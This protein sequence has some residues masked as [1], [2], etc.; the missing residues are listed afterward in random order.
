MNAALILKYPNILFLCVHMFVFAARSKIYFEEEEG[1]EF[2]ET[3]TYAKALEIL[4]SENIVILSG[5]PGEGK[6]TMA[7]HLLTRFRTDRCINLSEPKDWKHIDF[8]LNLI[9][10]ILIDDIFGS[11]VL[12]E[13]LVKN[14]ERKLKDMS[15]IIK[16]KYI[17]VIITSRHYILEE[18]KQ[19]FRSLPLFK[20]KNI[21]LL[22]SKDLTHKEKL[23]IL[24]A[25]LKAEKRPVEH[26]DMTKCVMKHASVPENLL[27]TNEF[28]FG[29]P[30]SVNLFAR[31]D[32][33][34]DK[35]PDF[36]SQ[37]NSFV[38]TCIQQLYENEEQFLALTVMWG[39]K[40]HILKKSELD[41]SILSNHLLEFKV[42]NKMI[43]KLRKSL[44][45]HVGGLLHFSRESGTYSFSHNVICDVVGLVVAEENP[46][47]VLA[48]CTREFMLTYVTT[49]STD[50]EFKFCVDKYLFQNLA[51]RLIELMVDET[52][53]VG[54][55]DCSSSITSLNRDG[56]MESRATPS[57]SFDFSFVK[58]ESFQNEHFVN[59][60]L[61]AVVEKGKLESIFGAEVMELS[62][63]FLR[64]GLKTNEQKDFLLSYSAFIG[65]EVFAKRVVAKNLLDQT[66]LS[67]DQKAIEYTMTL[68][69]AVHHQMFSL[70]EILLQKDVIVT[71]EVLYIAAHKSDMDIL[72][73]LLGKQQNMWKLPNV[74]ILNGNNALIVAAKKGFTKS[75]RCFIASGYNLTARNKDG[76]SAL[77]KAIVYRHE[78]VCKLL[79]E[80]GVPLNKATRKFKRR[81][82][83]TAIDNG[84]ISATKC[85]LANGGTLMTRDHKGFY[86]IH[87]AAL[88]RHYEIVYFLLEHDPGQANLLTKTYGAKSVLKGK[89]VFHIAL[90]KKDEKLLDVLLSTKA[91]PNV[92]DWFGRTVFQESILVG[93]PKFINKLKGVADMTIPDKDGVT[94]LHAAVYKGYALLVHTICSNPAVRVNAKDK[95][96]ETPLHISAI[97]G[98]SEI[99]L[100]LASKYNA[101]W[102]MVS[103]RGDTILHLVVRKRDSL[104]KRLESQQQDI[105]NDEIADAVQQTAGNCD[106]TGKQNDETSEKGVCEAQKS[107][108]EQVSGT[109]S[110][111]TQTGTCATSSSTSETASPGHSQSGYNLTNCVNKQKSD[112]ACQLNPN[113][114]SHKI[115]SIEAKTRLKPHMIRQL[116]SGSFT[117]ANDPSH[118]QSS[119]ETNSCQDQDTAI[120]QNICRATLES[121]NTIIKAFTKF[122]MEFIKKELT[123]KYGEKIVFCAET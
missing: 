105:V 78:D 32:D 49:E 12:D 75:V 94:P 21:Q 7:K 29:F 53:K 26:T 61:D 43:K 40:A 50:D 17:Y 10:A 97:R 111:R 20:N 4:E 98:F 107:L 55:L 108:I 103:K 9:D 95:N 39:N 57:F 24:E 59:V 68:L 45:H 110:I 74:E 65:L 92:T 54:L 88:N 77:D 44:D 22:S 112:D 102:R 82:I 100:A 90:C 19:L 36:F 80:A 34:F 28:L 118:I 83:H 6:T 16:K 48:F 109:E 58:H 73:L 85:L 66:E 122:D 14:W 46:D 42:E 93:D 79:V 5:H 56:K 3:T 89:S 60:F 87:T 114:G 119:L 27:G 113:S 115:Y 116:I 81:P 41:E 15:K 35:G 121:C 86:P 52:S 99:F 8:S 64:Y 63:F 47:E 91:N 101:D 13:N 2:V 120:T 31:Q 72:K 123:N 23:N 18:T 38:K 25:H 1:N 69:F 62:G 76:F 106:K 104:R 51:D 11:G 70:V 117:N 67:N 33:L 30:E 84:L 96:G 71:E 37:P